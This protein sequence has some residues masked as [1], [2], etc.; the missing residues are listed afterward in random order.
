M[1]VG[2]SRWDCVVTRPQ[3]PL[4][5]P[6]REDTVRWSASQEAPNPENR[7]GQHF[8]VFQPPELWEIPV[9]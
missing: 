5:S 3:R 8:V 2:A 1:M 7:T 9:V 4:L 6:L